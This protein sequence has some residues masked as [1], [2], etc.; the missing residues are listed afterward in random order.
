MRARRN[1]R[2]HGLDCLAGWRL[3]DMSGTTGLI[4]K[5]AVV[6]GASGGLGEP[7]WRALASA[8][9]SVVVGYNRSEAAAAAL[10]AR[11][12]AI[13]GAAHFALSMPM[14]DSAALGAAASAVAQ[15][16]GRVDILVNCAGTTR[17]VAHDDLDTLDDA[18]IDA[19][20]TTNVRGTF[21]ATRAFRPLLAAHGDGL[22]VNI[23]SIASQTAIGSN[24]IYC[25]SKAAVDNMTRSL[26]RAR[27][28]AGN[29]RAVDRAGPRRYGIRQIPGRG[30]AR[31]SESPHATRSAGTARR[32]RRRG[33]GRCDAAALLD[34]LEYRG[35]RRT[36][37]SHEQIHERA[38]WYRRLCA[39]AWAALSLD[40]TVAR[41]GCAVGAGPRRVGGAAP[42]VSCA[43][44]SENR[45]DWR[46]E[47][48]MRF[49]ALTR[50]P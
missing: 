10:A 22:I 32:G 17:F 33:G 24:V 35:R 37:R 38:R 44:R 14:T 7:I 2:R 46:D 15:R 4:G 23:L 5:V 42:S 25:A 29:P 43:G 1:E 48:L 41:S 26:A 18:L 34:W 28:G 16:A 45:R 3:I 19:I 36:P 21:A 9:A 50:Q 47:R 40:R 8:G 39:A 27:A 6:T 11:L 49:A 12:R 31:R 20:L 30:L 13:A